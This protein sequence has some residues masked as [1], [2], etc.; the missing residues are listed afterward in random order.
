MTRKLG[1]IG[2]LVLVVAMAVV[3][4]LVS[5]SWSALAPTA[6]EIR[7]VHGGGTAE[8]T[9]TGSGDRALSGMSDMKRATDAHEGAVEEA[10]GAID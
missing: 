7:A 10:M 2:I 5:K 9:A 4:V 1:S 8:G 6:T 3:L